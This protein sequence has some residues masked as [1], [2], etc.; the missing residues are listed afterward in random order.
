[1]NTVVDREAKNALDDPVSNYIPYTDIKPFIVTYILKRWQ[2]SWD[3]QI[4]NKLHEMHSLVGKTPCSYGQNRIGYMIIQC[5][6]GFP[7]N[8]CVPMNTYMTRDPC[9]NYMFTNSNKAFINFNNFLNKR[10][11]ILMVQRMVIE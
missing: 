9:E 1:V 2:D 8:D 6:L 11:Y 3:Q 4:H 7:V 5:V 10:Q